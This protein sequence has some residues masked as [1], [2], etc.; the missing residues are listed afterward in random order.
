MKSLAEDIQHR[1]ALVA[2]EPG[3]DRQRANVSDGRIK[4]C[5]DRLADPTPAGN[6]G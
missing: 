4:Y 3:G 6:A 1:V 2:A 5:N